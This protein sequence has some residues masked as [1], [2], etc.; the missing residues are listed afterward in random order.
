MHSDLFYL[1]AQV[2]NKLAN[3]ADQSVSHAVNNMLH[4]SGSE[5]MKSPCVAVSASIACTLHY[6]NNFQSVALMTIECVQRDVEVFDP[7]ANRWQPIAQM[8]D[9]RAYF[10]G[11]ACQGSLYAIGGL[12]PERGTPNYNHTSEKYD[13]SHDS[14]RVMQPAA[15]ALSAR[16]FM[17]ACVV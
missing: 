3:L 1:V 9:T 8:N 17:S 4:A 6:D 11:V 2:S 14:W 12:S 15:N 10:A 16:A 13:P 7:R 5:L